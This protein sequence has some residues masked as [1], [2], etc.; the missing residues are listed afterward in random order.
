MYETNNKFDL[1]IWL[2]QKLQAKGQMRVNNYIYIIIFIYIWQSLIYFIIR[3]IA[4]IHIF[5][6][7]TLAS[8][9]C[10]EQRISRHRFR[11]VFT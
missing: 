3:K 10:L 8:R 1:Y 6:C 5:R 2:Q 4:N 7:L 9:C 11:S